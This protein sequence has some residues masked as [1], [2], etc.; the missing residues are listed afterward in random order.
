MAGGHYVLE[1]FSAPDTSNERILT[2][3]TGQND[4]VHRYAKFYL[5]KQGSEES[6]NGYLWDINKDSA[7]HVKKSLGV[8]RFGLSSIRVRKTGRKQ[9][10]GNV[11]SADANQSTKENP[12]NRKRKT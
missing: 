3:L 4:T 2:M 7:D 9:L 1:I 6:G 10:K 12:K 8:L 5:E 11:V